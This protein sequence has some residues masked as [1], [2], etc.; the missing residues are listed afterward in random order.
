MLALYILST[1]FYG[2]R[3]VHHTTRIIQH[4]FF[5]QYYQTCT[6]YGGISFHSCPHT[7]AD[8]GGKHLKWRRYKRRSHTKEIVWLEYKAHHAIITYYIKIANKSCYMWNKIRGG[9]NWFLYYN[10]NQKNVLKKSLHCGHDKPI[11]CIITNMFFVPTMN[12]WLVVLPI[13]VP[14]DAP[15]LNGAST[16]A[17]YT[18]LLLTFPLSVCD[19]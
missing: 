9:T 19:A 14:A 8:I 15:A 17:V 11:S 10:F 1:T 4:W 18:A 3:I 16:W 12:T 7:W 2:I 6:Q 13:T 5:F